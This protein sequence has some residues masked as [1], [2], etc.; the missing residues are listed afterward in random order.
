MYQ[1]SRT[2]LRIVRCWLYPPE[3]AK[4]T[5]PLTII[6]DLARD[7]ARA[8]SRVLRRPIRRQGCPYGIARQR[9]PTGTDLDPSHA[10]NNDSDQ[11]AGAAFGDVLIAVLNEVMPKAWTQYQSVAAE[12][13]STSVE[14]GTNFNR[15]AAWSAPC[16]PEPST[17]QQSRSSTAS[18]T[19]SLAVC[20]GPNCKTPS[21]ASSLDA[22]GLDDTGAIEGLLMHPLSEDQQLAIRDTS[23]KAGS[24]RHR[25]YR[26]ANRSKP[27]A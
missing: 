11:R 20:Y 23:P 3:K 7:S 13:L 1:L 15:S 22:E 10:E 4:L 2:R 8:N 21:P 5:Q 14:G 26:Y 25:R 19:S 18:S 6:V 16:T 27:A 24:R 12:R 9:H 17:S